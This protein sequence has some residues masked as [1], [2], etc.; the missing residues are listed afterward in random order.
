M[1]VSRKQKNFS[2]FFA[3]FLKS[4]LNFENF[5]KKDGCHTWG[6]SE[7]TDCGKHGSINV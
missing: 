3:A 2:K 5:Q 7:I 1:Q 6:I 4:R